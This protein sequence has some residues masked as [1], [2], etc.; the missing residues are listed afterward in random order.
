MTQLRVRE[1]RDEAGRTVKARMNRTPP[2]AEA[3]VRSALR[4]VQ[5]L[6][7]LTEWW[8]GPLARTIRPGEMSG[9]PVWIPFCYW[10][11]NRRLVTADAP[12]PRDANAVDLSGGVIGGKGNGLS[13]CEKR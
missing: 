6:E 3:G 4:G 2:A 1:S 5:L 11:L 13:L 9:Q 8:Y 7:R 10:F 12:A